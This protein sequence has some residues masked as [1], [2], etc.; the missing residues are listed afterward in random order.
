MTESSLNYHFNGRCLNHVNT[1]T[2]LLPVLQLRIRMLALPHV[3]NTR[4]PRGL[5][6]SLP[7][8]PSPPP[9]PVTSGSQR[10]NRRRGSGPSSLSPHTH[11][12]PSAE[13]LNSRG[14]WDCKELKVN[15]TAFPW[16][17]VPTNWIK[18]ETRFSTVWCYSII[19][20]IFTSHL[21]LQSTIWYI[22]F[23]LLTKKY[24]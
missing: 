22:A 23:F 17:L 19:F 1:A 9:H 10:C 3:R 7:F 14:P 8:R 15:A 20:H 12:R 24:D 18:Y 16:Q 2:Y 4:S 5:R 21:T 13:P 6:M 11:T